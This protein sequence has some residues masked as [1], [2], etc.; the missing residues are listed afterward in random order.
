MTKA[1]AC[2]KLAL[3]MLTIPGRPIVKKNT[4]RIVGSGKARRR[5]LSPKYLAWEQSAMLNAM[6]VLKRS[7][8]GHLVDYPIRLLLKFYFA[9]RQAE[10][11]VSNLVE[12]P[13]DLLVKLGVLKDDRLVHE[14][15]A[16]KFFGHDPRTE[17]SI[18]KYQQEEKT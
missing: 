3:V 16:F 4:Q 12:G 1:A 6:A 13:Q 5:I 14:L 17:I 11:D 9:D 2:E 15:R 7:F 8:K 18:F 10:A